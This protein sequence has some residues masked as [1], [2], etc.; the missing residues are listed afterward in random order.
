MGET[1]VRTMTRKLTT[2]P[3]KYGIP[4]KGYKV[5]FKCPGS[6]AKTTVDKIAVV[7]ISVPDFPNDDI[8]C[9]SAHCPACKRL[10]PLMI[11]NRTKKSCTNA[12]FLPEKFTIND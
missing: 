7:D 12:E 1:Q 2:F 10:H 5:Q 8:F 11:V 9:L 3:A 4:V 6:K